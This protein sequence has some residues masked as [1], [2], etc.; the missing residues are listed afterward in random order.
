MTGRRQLLVAE[1]DPQVVSVLYEALTTEGGY[2]V[3]VAEDGAAALAA[4]AQPNSFDLLLLD[5]LLPKVSGL[6]VA[7][8][9]I[10][11][12]VP[13]LL[14]SGSLELTDAAARLG[15]GLLAKPYLFNDLFREVERTISNT[16]GNPRLAAMQRQLLAEN[17]RRLHEEC[18]RYR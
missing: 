4:L 16:C 17:I 7:S 18:H 13:V 6:A 5:L 11:Q 3:M 10:S 2:G 9:A 15:V 8:H 12:D 1:D 14:M